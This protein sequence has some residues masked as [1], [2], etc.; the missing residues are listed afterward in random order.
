MK[1]AAQELSL[2]NASHLHAWSLLSVSL[3]RLPAQPLAVVA[4]VA[5]KAAQPA[6][7]AVVVAESP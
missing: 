4:T 3:H 5:L 7:E 1:E 2:H 6:V